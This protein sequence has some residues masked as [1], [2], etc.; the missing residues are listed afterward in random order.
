M[1]TFDLGSISAAAL[2]R[3]FRAQAITP[4]EAAEHF[5]ARI[6]AASDP[7]IFITVTADRARREADAATKRYRSNAPLGPLDGVPVAWKDLFDLEGTTTTAGSEIYRSAPPAREDAVVVRNLAVAGMVSLGKVN[8][9]EFAYSGLGLNPH[10]GTPR[11]PY[12]AKLHRVPGGSSSGSAVA[13]AEGLAPVAI[14]TDTGGSVRIPAAFNGLAGFKTAEKSIDKTG[15]FPLS[16][17]LDTV[18]PLART[19]EDCLL[20]YSALRGAKPVGAEPASFAEL[21]LVVPT[22]VVFDEAEDTVV[23][24]FRALMVALARRGAT[25]VERRIAAFDGVLATAAHGNITAA[26]AYFVHRPLVD[27]PDIARID[28]RVVT[29]IM[30]GAQMSAYDLLSLYA[31]RTD[32]QKTLRAEL[33]GALLAY[34]TV[35]HTAPLVAPLEA[36]QELFHAVNVKTLRNTML[37]NF[38]DLPGFALPSGADPD[39]LPTSVLISAP[40]GSESQLFAAALAVESAMER[41]ARWSHE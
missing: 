18:G 2:A 15:V 41:A 12:D 37:G 3:A 4:S 27:G 9:S 35:P 13:V 25:I 34:P 32:L 19:V 8:L 21:H 11:N 14:G 20:L 31:A 40:S 28:P 1:T 10:F 33:D 30:R 6:A 7:T 24:N 17:T 36:S 16:P 39:G 26:D 38:L 22:N 5:L 29:R 23:A